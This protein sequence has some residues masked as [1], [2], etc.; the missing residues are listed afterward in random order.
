MLFWLKFVSDFN[1]FKW[2]VGYML[3]LW[4]NSISDHFTI[5]SS[6][7]KQKC[8]VYCVYPQQRRLYPLSNITE[9]YLDDRRLRPSFLAAFTHYCSIIF[10]ACLHMHCSNWWKVSM[11]P[12]CINCLALHFLSMS[13]IF[14]RPLLYSFIRDYPSFNNNF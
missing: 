10:T 11:K 8:S 4:W 14:W 7:T 2:Y 6:L 5:H 9:H 1:Y 13:T 3:G 12:R